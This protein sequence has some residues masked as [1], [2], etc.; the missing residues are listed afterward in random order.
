MPRQSRFD[1]S[2]ARKAQESRWRFL[3]R[4]PDFRKDLLRLS[5]LKSIEK[6]VNDRVKIADK[7]G[8][9]TIPGRAIHYAP[10]LKD[11]QEIAFFEPFGAEDLVAYSPIAVTELKE[12][13]FLFFRVDLDHP[14]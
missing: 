7:W 1:A 6:F 14:V 12:N 4:N 11:P 8:L 9:L 5:R 2:A 10:W 3:I 13:R